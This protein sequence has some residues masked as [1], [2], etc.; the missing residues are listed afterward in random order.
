MKKCKYCTNLEE[1]DGWD[2]P[3]RPQYGQT[4]LCDKCGASYY[5]GYGNKIIHAC[6]EEAEFNHPELTLL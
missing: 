1:I 6:N 4:F 2:C 3:D 5:R